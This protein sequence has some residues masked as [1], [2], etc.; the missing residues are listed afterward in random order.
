MAKKKIKCQQTK[1]EVM[2]VIQL[3][4]L[5]QVV[6]AP[7]DFTTPE[8]S[9]GF[10]CSYAPEELILAAGYTPVRL[11]GVEGEHSLAHRHLQ[12]YACSLV[13]GILEEGLKG[14][15]KNLAAIVFP[16][17]CDAIRRLSDIWRIN[18][19][20]PIHFDLVLPVKLNTES[21]QA[22]TRELLVQFRQELAE[23][24]GA[25]I[26]DEG[27]KEAIRLMNEIRACLQE[28]D[29][30]RAN[31]P[32]AISARDYYTILRAG[33]VM[34][35]RLYLRLIQEI[36][37][38]F[39]SQGEKEE[40]NGRVL[41]VGGMCKIPEIFS[42]IEEAGGWIVGDDLCVGSRYFSTLCRTEGDPLYAI[43]E[44]ILVRP[45]CPAK[46]RGIRT[47]F[48]QIIDKAEK[49]GAKGVIFIQYKFCD[50]HAFDYPDLKEA[51]AERGLPTLLIEI[52]DPLPAEGQIKTRC[53]AFI[54]MIKGD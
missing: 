21:A 27:L 10:V 48:E 1:K 5:K 39:K 34:D 22:Y 24:L 20:G 14:E 37:N 26:T 32:S 15:R 42:D 41:L 53:E 9:V 11:F 30:L 23:S 51:L 19:K 31:G 17:A 4:T 16:D 54:E 13:R 40:K 38:E 28:I 6:S 18:V 8:A 36:Y 44:R 25:I 46:H 52:E 29:R 49:T 45:L 43:A 50:P 35:R 33:M 2:A 47:R 12:S 3:E 7:F